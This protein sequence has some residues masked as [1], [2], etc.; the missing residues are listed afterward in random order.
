[1]SLL[2]YVCLQN[3]SE[4]VFISQ[5]A[6]RAQSEMY[7]VLLWVVPHITSVTRVHVVKQV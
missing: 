1:M 4:L 5:E 2:L 7:V 3:V 6:Y